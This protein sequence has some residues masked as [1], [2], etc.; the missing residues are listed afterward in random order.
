VVAGLLFGC[1]HPTPTPIPKYQAAE[2][3]PHAQLLMRG[4]VQPGETYG[5]YLFSDALA[6]KGLQRVGVGAP[7]GDPPS[8]T[9]TSGFT[10][11]EVFLTKANKSY[12]RVVWSFDPVAGRR[13]LVTASSTPA[14]CNARILDATDP[15]HIVVERNARRRDAGQLLC[16]P[17]SQTITL[18]EAEARAR[19]NGDADL[20]ISSTPSTTPSEHDQPPAVSE[21]DLG[22]LKPQ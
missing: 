5:V 13:Y 7:A 8:A 11:A 4:A 6:C 1:A 9:I 17:L 19:A 18:A 12:C 15:H 21:D 20:P 2:N 22:G 10:T 14:G 16:R 3:A